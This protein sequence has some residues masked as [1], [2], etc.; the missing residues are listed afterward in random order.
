LK[1]FFV[2]GNMLTGNI[3]SSLTNLTNLYSDWTNIGYNGLHTNDDTVRTFLNSK[4]PDWED[5]Q[6]LAPTNVF[7]AIITTSSLRVSWTPCHY[8]EAVGGYAVFY[9][10]SVG[11]SWVYAG[12]I[13]DK[14]ASSLNVN[15]FSEGT[16][17][18]VAVKSITEP[19]TEN[20]NVVLS[21]YSEAVSAVEDKSLPFGSFDTPIDGSTAAGSLPVTGWALDDAGIDNVKIYREQGNSLVYIGDALLVEGAR[22]DVAA[23]Y[24]GYPNK[25]KAGWGYMMLTNFLPGSGNGTFVLHAIATD[26]VGKSTSLGTRTIICDN[27]SAVKPFGAIDT[28][29]QGGA[30]SGG[31]FV[32]W[33]WA[34]T[35]RP[36]IIPTDG[37]TIN[38]WVDGVNIGNPVY[39]VFR[40]D[41]AGLFPD[42]V[43]SNGAIG[44]FY[45]D[46]TAYANGVHTIQWTARDSTGNSEGI[47]SRYFSIQNTGGARA[48][49]AASTANSIPK[50][51][52]PGIGVLKDLPIDYS[53]PLKIRKGF[54]EDIEALEI[55]PGNEGLTKIVIKELERLELDFS[56]SNPGF[57][58]IS[59]YMVSGGQLR[60]LP[61][62][63][64][65]P[66]GERKFYWQ[67]GP[68]FI[69]EYRFV[70][71]EE[72]QGMTM[73]RRDIIIKIVPKFQKETK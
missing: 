42:Y 8:T 47:G 65:L 16:E 31:K 12:T 48:S 61:I 63:S 52:V 54:V 73:S 11:G 5:T 37:S 7:G 51:S 19:H 53:A 58:Q 32:N 13:A 39:N 59:G 38:V 70:F 67:P 1:Y 30:A 46:T 4:D 15:V 68:G 25:T 45:L 2:D 66:A 10:T 18:Y 6:T 40:S 69:G 27:V 17:F 55:Y 72:E 41:I 43:N 56:N 24:P 49:S 23:S 34:L 3:P 50:A 64:T 28:P 35:P 44:Y 20:A 9:S 29:T 62:G 26:F 22:P 14:F 21:D 60:P 71:I 33:G 57:T 36:N